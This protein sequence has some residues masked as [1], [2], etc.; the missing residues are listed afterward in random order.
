MSFISQ[1]SYFPGVKGVQQI[2]GNN[3]GG[4]AA[5][6]NLFLAGF[7]AGGNSLPSNLIAI[8]GNSLGGGGP[9]LNGASQAQYAGSI[10]IG[11]NA[12][13][14][15]TGGVGFNAPVLG[16]GAN[17]FQSVKVSGNILAI[18]DNIGAAFE[19]NMQAAH[20]TFIGQE[21]LS[22]FVGQNSGPTACVF[23]GDQIMSNA[24]IGAGQMVGW[25][26]IGSGSAREW[27]NLGVS[28][29]GNTLI[30]AGICSTQGAT[31]P[32][33]NTLVGY[34]VG[35]QWTT[36]PSNNTVMGA[37]SCADALASPT[38]NVV[39]GG[40]ISSSGT[41]RNTLIGANQTTLGTTSSRNILI[42]AGAGQGETSPENDILII[43]TYDGAT[44]RPLVY[45]Y[46]ATGN[47]MLA[48]WAQASRAQVQTNGGT[49][50]IHIPNGTVGANH[51]A[52][53][54]YLYVLAGALHWRG[55][56]TD[57]ILAPA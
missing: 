16:I 51:D 25:T 53:G 8:G 7:N 26:I 31:N 52:G 55:T 47:L 21:V 57:T 35:I 19:A 40:N 14:A 29:T 30:G 12:F 10:V 41:D 3:A 36:S 56:A 2:I 11:Y 28:A 42:G 9:G 37:A 33:S 20:C 4:N 17:V 43:E 32:Q 27:D 49:N 46:L 38:N 34:Q 45:G 15:V 5:G 44:Q 48:G 1:P 23:V 39:L 24:G 50:Q 18:G 13:A 22:T 54:G 6:A